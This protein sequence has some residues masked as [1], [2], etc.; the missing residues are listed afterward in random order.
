M[1]QRWLSYGAMALLLLAG[2]GK[3]GSN[4]TNQ[5]NQGD[6]SA[7]Q[8]AQQQPDSSN[9]SSAPAQPSPIIIPTG[10]NIPVILTTSLSSYSNKSGDEFEGSIAAPVMVDG[11]EAIRKGAEVKGTV[12]DAKKQGAIKGQAVLSITLTSVRAGGRTH[13]IETSTYEATE[14]GKGK[15]SAEITGGGAALGALIGG[16][17]GGGKGAAIG[18][19]VGGGGG[20]AASA[21]TGGHNVEL[22]SE[23]RLTFKL[24][25][26]I[27]INP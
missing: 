19:G 2:C 9:S 1:N 7:N 6:N 25:Q 24:T 10:T 17:A 18:A 14:K 22:P 15:R 26:S 16:L 11:Q 12:V 13:S 4:A 21:K 27:T 8:S 3:S 23:T 5:S 20:L